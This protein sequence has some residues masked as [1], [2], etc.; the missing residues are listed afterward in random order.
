MDLTITGYV[1]VQGISPTLFSQLSETMGRRPVYL[2]T[3]S[4]IAAASAALASIP[5]SYSALLSLRM[6]QRFGSSVSTSIGYAVVADISAPSERVKTMA[7][8]LMMMN[9]VRVIELS[10]SSGPVRAHRRKED[11]RDVDA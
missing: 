1:L 8:V 4:I 9:L 10:T 2:L 11:S 3:F 6:L 5:T 7:P